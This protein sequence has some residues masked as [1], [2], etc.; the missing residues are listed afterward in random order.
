M[1]ADSSSPGSSSPGS[2]NG[3]SPRSNSE[4]DEKSRTSETASEI[5]AGIIKDATPK[6]VRLL[7][8]VPLTFPYICFYFGI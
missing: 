3:G 8:I 6:K 7:H 1:R 5:L 4:G 2:V